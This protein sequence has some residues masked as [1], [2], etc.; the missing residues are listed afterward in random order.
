MFSF[1][2]RRTLRRMDGTWQEQAARRRD[3]RATKMPDA[4]VKARGKKD[5]KR[6]CGGHEGR[7]HQAECRLYKDGRKTYLKGWRELVCRTCGKQL[8]WWAPSFG[9]KIKPSWVT[10]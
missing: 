5:R 4:P 9:P 6:W 1:L 7:E 10:L 3:E 2:Q 8:D